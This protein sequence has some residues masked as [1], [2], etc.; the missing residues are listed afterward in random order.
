VFIFLKDFKFLTDI[1]PNMRLLVSN[2]KKP[3]IVVDIISATV[4]DL[5][6]GVGRHLPFESSNPTI[7]Y[8]TKQ[9]A[10]YE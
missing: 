8:I 4:T 7:C 9:K 1:L 2:K 3:I 6:A 5:V 10:D